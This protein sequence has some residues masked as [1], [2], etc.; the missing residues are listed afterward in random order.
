[1]FLFRGGDPNIDPASDPAA[2][3]AYLQTWEEWMG[4]LAAN[5]HAPS[6][7]SL[8]YT[9]KVVTGKNMQVTDGPF[10]EGKELV[11]G[12]VIIEAGSLDE[13]VKLS[14]GCP[15]YTYDGIVEVREIE[16]YAD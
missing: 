14:R 8:K 2:F 10:V 3:G 16:T 6:G 15:I 13:A 1:M 7:D 4:S 11:G 12:Y 5:G 9:G